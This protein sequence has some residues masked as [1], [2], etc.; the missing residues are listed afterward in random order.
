MVVQGCGVGGYAPDTLMVN[1]TIKRLSIHKHSM[2]G[3]VTNQYFLIDLMIL[4]SKCSLLFQ[5]S[6]KSLF[7][8][9]QQPLTFNG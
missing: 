1:W 7:F 6:V 2:I 5:L 4:F 9:S 8:P 3:W